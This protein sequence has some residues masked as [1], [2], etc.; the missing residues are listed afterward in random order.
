MEE[1][2]R[3]SDITN[4]LRCPRNVYYDYHGHQP[5]RRKTSSYITALLIKEMAQSYCDVVVSGDKAA[6]LQELLQN[7]AN[8]LPVIYREELQ[9]IEQEI[10]SKAVTYLESH[11]F[12]I[13]NG[14]QES[15]EKFGTQE[16]TA[17]Y[18]SHE[19][20]PVLYSQKFRLS[21]SPDRL[22]KRDDNIFPSIIRTGTAP[23]TGIWKDDRIRITALSILVEEEYDILVDHGIV[24][25]ARY[26][27]VRE[28]KI[29]RADRRNV[30]VLAGRI[31]KIRHGRLPQRPKDA[32]CDYCGYKEFCQTSSTLA[33]RFF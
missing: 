12:E 19:S 5:I 16:L 21:G 2:I 25:Y 10:L 31:K 28:V 11:L 18:T 13:T 14:I 3:V 30:L 20:E 7:S 33:S 17:L 6:A 27:F 9:D 8:N 26:G 1:Y 24:E 29:K 23:Q 32:P 15:I 22:I 4:Y